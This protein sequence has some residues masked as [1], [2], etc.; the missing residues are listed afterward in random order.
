MKIGYFF[1]ANS[2]NKQNNYLV[3]WDSKEGFDFIESLFVNGNINLP[4]Q[5]YKHPDSISEFE[6]SS[7]LHFTS[8]DLFRRYLSLVRLKNE[9]MEISTVVSGDYTDGLL[10]RLRKIQRNKETKDL[11]LT[12]EINK[13]SDKTSETYQIINDTVIEKIDDELRT[14]AGNDDFLADDGLNMTLRY[15][16]QHIINEGGEITVRGFKIGDRKWSDRELHSNLGY[17]SGVLENNYKLIDEFNK[18]HRLNS[19]ESLNSFYKVSRTDDLKDVSYLSMERSITGKNIGLV[20]RSKSIKKLNHFQH[21]YSGIIE[22]GNDIVYL[23][24]ILD[25]KE[26]LLLQVTDRQVTETNPLNQNDKIGLMHV[27]SS[28]GQSLDINNEKRMKLEAEWRYYKFSGLMEGFRLS[29]KPVKL[30]NGTITGVK[31]VEAGNRNNKCDSC[32]K[33]PCVCRYILHW[34]NYSDLYDS[35]NNG[36][37][38]YGFSCERYLLGGK[39]PNK[40][41]SY[42]KDSH[43]IGY[44]DIPEDRV[45]WNDNSNTRD[46]DGLNWD[47]YN[48]QLDMDQQDPEFWG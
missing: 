8:I 38:Y 44:N 33:S 48:D 3:P 7:R 11:E 27:T 21:D 19:V 9:A 47:L 10:N 5:K 46:D 1:P 35:A 26:K 25:N 45:L 41:E 12:S 18:K 23:V 13:L 30:K 4:P 36:L 6:G 15:M 17:N 28:N 43:Y 34:E 42:S 31:W 39:H 16:F 2:N 32:G 40:I 37:D 14:I 20:F 22:S 24:K 29:E